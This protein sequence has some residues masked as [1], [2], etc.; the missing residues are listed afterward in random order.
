MNF[1]VNNSN[2]S[3]FI[4]DISTAIPLPTCAGFAIFFRKFK[5]GL[6]IPSNKLNAFKYLPVSLFLYGVSLEYKNKPTIKTL[7]NM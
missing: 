5:N 7:T 4:C 3:K 1:N 2:K 6:K